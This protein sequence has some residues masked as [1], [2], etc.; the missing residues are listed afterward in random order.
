MEEGYQNNYGDLN[1][2]AIGNAETANRGPYEERPIDAGKEEFVENPTNVSQSSLG[3]GIGKLTANET[4][5]AKEQDYTDKLG[6]ILD[7]ASGKNLS[8]KPVK[9]TYLVNKILFLTVIF[10]LFLDRC[11]F[12]GLFCV[13]GIFF[14]EINLC[15]KK[16]LYKWLLLLV[17]SL[18][19]DIFSFLDILRYI[20]S[21]SS[22]QVGSAGATST[23]FGLIMIAGNV[24]LKLAE[25]FGIWKMAINNKNNINDDENGEG[26]Y[27]GQ[28]DGIVV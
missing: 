11:D 26:N 27:E 16:Y 17:F 4:F 5:N 12:V 2:N 24:I 19:L 14:T 8:S 3:L 6:S 22:Y 15:N 28:N 18:L 13:A 7:K 1:E 9:L 20:F 10:C 21:G 25:A 23:K